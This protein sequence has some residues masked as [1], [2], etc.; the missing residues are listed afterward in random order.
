M[1]IKRL[2][3]YIN[4]YHLLKIL[5]IIVFILSII[6]TNICQKHSVYLEDET[7]FTGTVFKI[8]TTPNK[9]TIYLK[10]SEKLVVNYYQDI[11]ENIKIGDKIF[12]KGKLKLPSNNTIPNLFNYR[13]YLD[14]NDIHYIVVASSITKTANNTNIICHIKSIISNRIDKIENSTSYLR[15]FILGDTSSL[16]ESTLASYRENGISHLFSISG[17]HISLFAAILFYFL[18]RISYNNYYNYTIV[19]SFLIFYSLLVGSSVS[20]IRSLIMYIL[21]AINKL[22]NLKIKSIDIMSLTLI[23]TLLINPYLIIN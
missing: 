6:Y 7:E 19:I 14:N 10:S 13:K 12:V 11:K 15:I 21:F 1:I 17:M 9:T 8:K 4:R 2:V 3:F 18:K 5:A 16:D 20:V 22:F 23:I